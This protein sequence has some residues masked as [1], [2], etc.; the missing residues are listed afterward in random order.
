MIDIIGRN[1]PALTGLNVADTSRPQTSAELN[2]ELLAASDEEEIVDVI[3][4]SPHANIAIPTPIRAMKT[5]QPP[6]KRAKPMPSEND[7]LFELKGEKLQAEIEKLRAERDELQSRSRANQ[8]RAQ[9]D[10]FDYAMRV[11]H[12]DML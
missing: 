6:R 7:E 3:E 8:A 1:S 2:T 9:L 10:E 12:E 4:A 5:K 11:K